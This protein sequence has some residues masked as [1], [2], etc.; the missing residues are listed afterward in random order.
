MEV[1]RTLT[2]PPKADDDRVKHLELFEA[3]LRTVP[4]AMAIIDRD[5]RYIKVNAACA[6]MTNAPIEAHAGRTLRE[7]NPLLSPEM[8]TI[9][10]R[11]IATGEP[12]LNYRL[13]RPTPHAGTGMLEVAMHITPFF[14]VDGSVGGICSTASDMTEW[15]HLQEQFFQAQKLE[16]VGKL[17]ASIAHDFNNIITV[18]GSYCDLVLM[19]LP[20][21]SP[22]RADIEEILGAS[23]RATTLARRMLGTA[24][25]SALARTPID[26]AET[27]RGAHDLLKH[28]ANKD[29]TVEIESSGDALV[30]SG[31]TTQLEQILLNLVINAVDA[32]PAGG[33]IAIRTKPTSVLLPRITRAGEI[34][35]GDYVELTVTDSGTG[36]DADTLNHV[37]EPFFTTKPQ[38]KGT[39][40]GL[41]TVLGIA[42]E[43]NGGVDVESEV[44]KGT[45]FRILFPMLMP[46]TSTASRLTPS[47]GTPAF[48][49][50][51][52]TLLL[53]NDEDALRAG[54]ARVLTRQGYR[55]LEARHGGEALRI[56]TDEPAISLV[57]SDLHMPGVGGHELA[58]RLR[59]LGRRMP[60]LFM[61]SSQD[62]NGEPYGLPTNALASDR[63]IRGPL[64]VD[65]LLTTVRE[66]LSRLEPRDR[67]LG[68]SERLSSRSRRCARDDNLGC[69]DDV[70][71]GAVIAAR[72]MTVRTNSRV[73]VSPL[74]RVAQRPGLPVPATRRA[75]ETSERRRQTR[76]VPRQGPRRHPSASARRGR[77]ASRSSRRT[78]EARA[79]TATASPSRGAAA[80]RRRAGRRASRWRARSDTT[81]RCTRRVA[82][83]ATAAGV[84]KQALRRDLV[85]NSRRTPPRLP[86]QR[87]Y[88]R[89]A[90]A[91]SPAG[92]ARRRS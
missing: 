66:M 90:P 44:G 35:A 82:E 78:S 49:L 80:R 84:H 86:R 22:L 61:S 11:V 31:D 81:P 6:K 34:R 5:L 71:R 51:S 18:I 4:I 48:P 28:A 74:P 59:G 54:L 85:S 7:I 30:I 83:R 65:E 3:A 21:A 72:G 15:R 12:C 19:E 91:T 60:I 2:V 17:A 76:R 45:T 64:D 20:T 14:K 73:P 9:M 42:R 88:A 16:A 26:V 32:M 67:G 36:M 23:N 70:R 37:F 8:E 33:A 47:R 89:A 41:A 27:V 68:S 77:R 69:G 57:V 75:D 24:R 50:G 29:V 43:L 39:G 79:R 63:F 25:H 1:N 58:D 62:A 38:G 92:S 13:S 53:V 52:E 46:S 56:I 55:V 10:R 87:L 40:L